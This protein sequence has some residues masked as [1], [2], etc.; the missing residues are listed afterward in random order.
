MKDKF[1]NLSSSEVQSLINNWIK[2]ERD[3][4]IMKR[5]YIDGITIEKLAEEKQVDMSARN[6]AYILSKNT[7]LLLEKIT[8][9]K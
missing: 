6:V 2:N 4:Y 1:R 7:K 5:R 9:E 3:R 8:P